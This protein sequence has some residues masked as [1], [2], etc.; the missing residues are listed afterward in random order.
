LKSIR[1][2]EGSSAAVRALGRGGGALLFA[3]ISVMGIAAMSAALLQINSA[4]SRRQSQAADDKRAFYIA[5]AGLS[6]AY[7]G[8]SRGRTGQ[9]GSQA[10]PVAYGSGLFWVD[11]E[12]NDDGTFTLDCTAM[13]RGGRSSVGMVV[14]RREL[15]LAALGMY[16]GQEMTVEG[17]TYI[18]SYDSGSGEYEAVFAA[19][20]DDRNR[21]VVG[22][23]DDLILDSTAGRIVVHGH[24]FCG[25]EAEV[26]T[27]G[28]PGAQVTG[29]TGP[30]EAALD[31]PAVD[32]PDIELAPAVRHA[33]VIPM[34][35]TDEAGF[36]GITVGAGSVLI[37]RGPTTLV[38]GN[39]SLATGAE[40][41]FDTTDGPIELFV[42]QSALFAQR[43]IISNTTQDPKAVSVQVAPEEGFDGHLDLA[44]TG[45][46]Y[47]LIYAPES[48]VDV[49]ATCEL[50]GAAIADEL[51][52]AS[53]SKLHYDLALMSA[54]KNQDGITLPRLISWRIL[55]LPPAVRDRNMD[56]FSVMGV[57]EAT[58][59]SPAKAHEDVWVKLDYVNLSA[60]ATAYEGWYD[61]FDFGQAS[62][63]ERLRVYDTPNGELLSDMYY[64]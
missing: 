60:S 48:R 30:R 42:T 12:E 40:I 50:F 37:L 55:S 49:A 8:L 6:E 3:L 24:T 39:L 28:E 27:T 4:T 57:D 5:E 38:V 16:S 32:A 1:T 10:E 15:K 25:P 11:S 13:C 17:G 18:D 7:G 63:V 64:K 51:V 23:S 62:A 61:D 58:L 59:A 54:G 14:G 45:E 52:V 19:G 35:V 53:G 21:A 29:R 41:V 56:P 43:S 46:F 20:E 47:G 22:S 36:E 2:R 26:T 31:L 33:S 9:V 34:T 44:A